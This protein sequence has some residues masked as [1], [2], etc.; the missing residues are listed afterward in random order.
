MNTERV[1]EVVS[2]LGCVFSISTEKVA[3]DDRLSVAD[4]VTHEDRRLAVV[5]ADLKQVTADT[6]RKLVRKDAVEQVVILSPNQ[7]G[8]LL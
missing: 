5:A 1:L 6:V 4:T 7:P 2:V 8:V 3:Y